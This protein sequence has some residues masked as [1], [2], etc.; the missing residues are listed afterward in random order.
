MECAG[1]PDLAAVLGDVRVI[2]ANV[3]SD[4]TV[5]ASGI[6]RC[7]WFTATVITVNTYRA[8]PIIQYLRTP[9]PTPSE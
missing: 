9:F 4:A 7:T 5:T 1:I 6:A 8:A 2:P 3:E